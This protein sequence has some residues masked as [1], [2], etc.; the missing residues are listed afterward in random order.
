M[1]TAGSNGAHDRAKLDRIVNHE[2]ENWFPCNIV[3][4]KDDALAALFYITD[5]GVKAIWCVSFLDV[6]RI[7]VFDL[8]CECAF[9]LSV[10][11]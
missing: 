6:H 2:R 7:V 8:R 10:L 5:C 9:T 11:L 4:V 3:N 1:E